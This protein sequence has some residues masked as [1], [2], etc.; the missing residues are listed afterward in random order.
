MS[1]AAA[2]HHPRQRLAGAP[3]G[4]GITGIEPGIASSA[5]ASCDQR[6]RVDYPKLQRVGVLHPPPRLITIR[7]GRRELFNQRRDRGRLIFLEEVPG[8]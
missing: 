7:Q 1:D 4:G 6:R 3:I 2:W 8:W 5:C